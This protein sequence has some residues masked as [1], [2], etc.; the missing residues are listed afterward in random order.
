MT[1]A[2][3]TANRAAAILRNRGARTPGPKDGPAIQR[4]D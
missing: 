3:Q 1:A 4:I 2:E